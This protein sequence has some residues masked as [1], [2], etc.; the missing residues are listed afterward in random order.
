[1]APYVKEVHIEYVLIIA[2][3]KRDPLDADT[4]RCFA[5]MRLIDGCAHFLDNQCHGTPVD[6]FRASINPPPEEPSDNRFFP[7]SYEPNLSAFQ[8]R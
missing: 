6:R 7:Y 5:I 2:L 1:M 4:I 3:P 8:I